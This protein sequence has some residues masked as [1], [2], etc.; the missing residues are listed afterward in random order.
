MPG[1]VLLAL[2]QFAGQTVAA[3]AITDVWE[4]ARTRF[5]RLLGRGD[6]RKTQVAEGWLTQTR[7]QLEAAEPGAVG[8][9]RQ[10]A[11]ERWAGRFSDLLDE[12]PSAEAALRAVAGPAASHPTFFAQALVAL[13][14]ARAQVDEVAIVG[15]LDAVATRAL[16]RVA[17]TGFRPNQVVAAAA[18]P[19]S[20]SIELLA[21]RT[22]VGGVP[23]AYV[24]HAFT[25]RLPVTGPA[26]LARLLARPPAEIG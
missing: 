15:S 14:L 7:A 13:D 26:A 20:S 16:V 1:E 10:A 25:C 12:D 23:A 2:A 24:C 11:Q 18:D 21:G 6:A 4:S 9:V 22:L 17:R 3:A 8:Q 19:G 5:A